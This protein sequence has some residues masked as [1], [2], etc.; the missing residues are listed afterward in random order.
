MATYTVVVPKPI[1]YG[2]GVV[3]IRING[4]VT[5]KD[6][7]GEDVED[8]YDLKMDIPFDVEVKGVPEPIKTVLEKQF[9][10]VT[11]VLETPTATPVPQAPP[12]PAPVPQAPPPPAPPLPPGEGEKTEEVE[13][14]AAAGEAGQG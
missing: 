10:N 4:S 11:A 1:G 3:P 9:E 14:E 13:G 7:K 8:R 6:K 5:V 2:V 12:P